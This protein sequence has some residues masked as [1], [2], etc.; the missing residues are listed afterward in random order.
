MINAMFL[1]SLLSKYV[2]YHNSSTCAILD[3]LYA[4]YANIDINQPIKLFFDQ[5]EDVVNFAAAGDSPCTPV[6]V[7]TITYQLS[8][9]TD[10]HPLDCSNYR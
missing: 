1:H 8:E 10:K 9:C 7:T 2:G 5:I 4:T 3:H 6:Q